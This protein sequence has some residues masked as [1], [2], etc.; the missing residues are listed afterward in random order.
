[1]R[2]LAVLAL[3][4]LLLEVVP[5]GPAHAA[6]GAAAPRPCPRRLLVLSAFPGEIDGLLNQ[7]TVEETVTVDDRRFFVGRLRGHGVVLALTGIGLVNA[8]ETATV[9]FARFRC[10]SSRSGIR[11]VVFSGVSG[12]R[13]AIGDV[14]V[15]RRWKVKDTRDPWLPVDPGMLAVAKAVQRAGAGLD[16]ATP[17][18]DAA[19]VGLDPGLVRTV[20]VEPPRI[21]VGGDGVSADPFGGRRFPCFPAGGDVF[22]CEPCRAPPVA[23]DV[24]RFLTGMAPFADPEFFLS[25]FESPPPADSDYAAE[26]MET[27]AV[28]RVAARN[29]TP[30]IAFRALSDGDGDPLMLP[31][32]PVQFFYYR[33]LAADN[34]AM[35]T[36]EF[37]E[38]WATRCRR[39]PRTRGCR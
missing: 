25:F 38:S 15:P 35:V 22:G 1:M 32:F 39:A 36:L 29:K 28:A 3:A 30:F 10:S 26:D 17:V 18:G 33:Q 8:H 21:I 31:G 14:T 24:A 6:F 37:L 19:C 12:G 2:R 11:G 23:P 5:A 9:A 27:A 13:T 34:A 4:V 20:S 16:A 7:T